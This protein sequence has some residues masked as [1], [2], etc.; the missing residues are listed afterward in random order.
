M[1]LN[2]IFVSETHSCFV[3]HETLLTGQP[4]KTVDHKKKEY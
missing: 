1:W 3:K 4:V 2:R